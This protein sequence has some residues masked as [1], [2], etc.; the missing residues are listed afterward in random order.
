MTSVCILSAA[1]RRFAITRLVL[2]QRQRLCGELAARGVDAVSLI[3]ADDENLDIAREYGCETVEAPNSPLGAK[4]NTG[5]Q[6]AARTGADFVVWIG[7][8]DWIHPDVF[9]PLIGRNTGSPAIVTG[10]RLGIVDIRTGMLQRLSSPSQYGAIPWLIDARLL[11]TK[12]AEPLPPKLD[13]GLDGALVRGLRLGRLP[14]TWEWH[15]PHDFRCIDFKTE[16]N[17]TPY[18]GLARN[19][20]VG[21]PEPAWPAL[22]AWFPAD[23]VEKASKLRLPPPQRADIPARTHVG[24]TAAA[25]APRVKERQPP[26]KLVHPDTGQAMSVSRAGYDVLRQRGWLVPGETAAVK[27]GGSWPDSHKA[28]D[29]LAEQLEVTWPEPAEGKKKLTVAEKIQALEAAGHTPTV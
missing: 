16:T 5:L 14:F 10:R 13:R 3:V 8:D 11:R 7:S 23:L 25:A 24:A 27:A 17:I 15:D 12:N 1:W 19:I 28:L 26:M 21:D 29:A 22:A 2:E 20:G 9:D 6:H 4:W 18:E